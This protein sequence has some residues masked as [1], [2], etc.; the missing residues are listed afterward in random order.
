MQVLPRAK[1]RK[2][3]EAESVGNQGGGD[4]LRHKEIRR[5][6]GAADDGW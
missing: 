1:W 5:A 6:R 4:V 3:R 2:S